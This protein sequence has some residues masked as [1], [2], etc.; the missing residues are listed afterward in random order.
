MLGGL[1]AL[2]AILEGLQG[3]GQWHHN[4]ISYR[5]TAEA[6]K[7][8]KFLWVAK[9]G[10]YATAENADRMLAERSESLISTEHASWVKVQEQAP[11][12]VKG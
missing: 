7:H 2:I 12:P 6:L 10:V 8:E 9:A 1:G 5:S 3:L 11:R 4:W